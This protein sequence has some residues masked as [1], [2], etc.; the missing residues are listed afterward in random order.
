MYDMIQLVSGT[1]V[2]AWGQGVWHRYTGGRGGTLK[3]RLSGMGQRVEHGNTW[4]GHGNTGSGTWEYMGGTWEFM[5]GTWEHRE[6]SMAIPLQNAF[7]L[8]F[9]AAPQPDLMQMLGLI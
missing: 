7:Q 6:W 5:G 4:V 9:L 8:T 2:G 1:G 3:H